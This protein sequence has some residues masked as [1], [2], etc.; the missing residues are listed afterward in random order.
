VAI[1]CSPKQYNDIYC[2]SKRC[3]KPALRYKP[4][5]D[6][7][8]CD[9]VLHTQA[10]SNKKHNNTEENQGV[11][12]FDLCTGDALK[13]LERRNAAQQGAS[14]QDASRQGDFRQSVT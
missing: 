5:R 11:A 1:F 14:R 4:W 6:K 10:L 9:K 7:V 2:E 8:L 12:R 3:I 13:I